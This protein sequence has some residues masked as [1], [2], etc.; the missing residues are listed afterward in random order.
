VTSALE[1]CLVPEAGTLRDAMAAIDAGGRQIALAIDPDGR[2]VGVA[3]DGDIRRAI[4]GGAGPDDPLA[5]HLSRAFVAVGPGDGRA[6]V[7]DLIRARR[8]GAVPVVD[9]GGRPIGLHLLQ[10]FLRPTERPNWAVVM[11]GGEGRRLRPLTEETPKPMLRVAGRPILERIVLHLVGHGIE[12][13]FLAVN[14]LGEQIEGHFG[15][16]AAFGARIEYLREAS[17]LGT[18]GALGLLPERP[19]RAVLVMNGDLVTQADLGGLLDFHE[20]RGFV[21]TVGIRRYLHEVPFGSVARDGDR[22]VGLEEKP[23]I[24]RDVSAGINALGPAML[25]RIERGR[26][27]GMPDLIGDALARDEAVGAFELEDDWIDIGQRE[28]LERARRGG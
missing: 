11:V 14:Y 21:A 25:E 24:V 16:G 9:G 13:I 26:P 3:T 1:R 20:S 27:I 18:A 10:E 2:L 28:Q 4:L 6:E 15:D 19:D 23:T 22:V 5:A 17:P 12:R 8:I 7:L